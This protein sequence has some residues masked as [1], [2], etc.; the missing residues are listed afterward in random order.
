MWGA[1]LFFVAEEDRHSATS[2]CSKGDAAQKVFWSHF[3]YAVVFSE[4][5]KALIICGV[6]CYQLLNTKIVVAFA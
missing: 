1:P 6:V 2:M 5:V 3:L 4:K